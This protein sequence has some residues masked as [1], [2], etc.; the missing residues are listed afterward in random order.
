MKERRKPQAEDAE[1]KGQEGLTS[2]EL[3]MNMGRPQS[4]GD[5]HKK[6]PNGLIEYIVHLCGCCFVFA[7]HALCFFL[8]YCCFHN[9]E[10]LSFKDGHQK[11]VD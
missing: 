11:G 10:N 5:S 1:S 7:V 8:V 6:K 3:W 4:E 9:E 2:S